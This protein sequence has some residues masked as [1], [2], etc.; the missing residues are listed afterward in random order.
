MSQKTH[1][2]S[3]RPS[4]VYTVDEISQRTPYA[5][6]KFFELI[7]MLTWN[8]SEYACFSVLGRKGKT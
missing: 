7:S 6:V 8:G 5:F 3:G 4:D 1:G 2:C